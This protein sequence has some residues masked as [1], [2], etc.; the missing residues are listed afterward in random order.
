LQKKTEFET[1]PYIKEKI[2]SFIAIKWRNFKTNLTKWYIFG[3]LKGKSPYEK[4][5]SD[6][7]TWTQFVQS[8]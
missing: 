6:E 3:H 5:T 2:M 7:E 8:R 4:Y 1:S